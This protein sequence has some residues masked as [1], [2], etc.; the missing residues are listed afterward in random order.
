MALVLSE[1]VRAI[2]VSPTVAVAQ[3]AMALAAQGVKVLDFSVGEPDQPTPAHVTRAGQDA[4]AAGQTRYTPSLGL[5]ALRAAVAERYRLDHG[6]GFSADH[7]AIT[8]GGKHALYA[9]C[10]VLLQPGQEVLVPV[11]AWPTFTEAVRLA[12]AQPVAVPTPAEEGFRL[13]AAAVERA[14]TAR[15]RALIVN[16]P[17]NPTGIAVP[18]DELLRIGELARERGLVLLFDDTYGRL[19]FGD[20]PVGGPLREL[21]ERAGEQLVILGT[22]SKTYCMTGWR[23]G[24]ILGPAAFV[25][26]CGAHFSHSTQCAATFAQHAAVEALLGPQDNVA[27]LV[28]EYRRRRDAVLA[29]LRGLPGVRCVSPDGGFYVFPDVS[30]RLGP[31]AR[32]TLELCTRLLDEERVALVPGEGFG[33]PGHVRL[34]FARSADDLRE[35]LARI[36]TFF[37]RMGA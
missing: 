8:L 16:S 6:L 24:W 20:D 25:K 34:S 13:T 29:S 22:A 14:L 26:A 21:A 4:L 11:P 1:R 7:V 31:G 37:G 3:R 10:Q 33:L 35:G 19:W 32:S 15:T 12:G 18:H 17:C 5:P 36:H 27:E 9:S 2:E 30:A 23:I 28:A